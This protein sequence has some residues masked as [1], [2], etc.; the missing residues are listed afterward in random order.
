LLAFLALDL[1]AAEPPLSAC[2]APYRSD[3]LACH[4][5]AVREFVVTV[6]G[7]STATIHHHR[8]QTSDQGALANWR[9]RWSGVR[10]GTRVAF[11]S[12]LYRQPGSTFA[13]ASAVAGGAS[14]SIVPAIAR[15]TVAPCAFAVLLAEASGTAPTAA[16]AREKT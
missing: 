5:V 13:T 1:A 8:H 6:A 15:S 7:F 14:S 10:S 11:R 12:G 3:E 9:A 4:R 16:V 2:P